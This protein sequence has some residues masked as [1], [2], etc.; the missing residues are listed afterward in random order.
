ME[1]AEFI[2]EIRRESGEPEIGAAQL[3]AKATLQTLAERLPHSE[4]LRLFL[5]LPDETK[6]WLRS[7]S[8]AGAFDIDEFLG[9]VARREGVDVETAFDH[10]RTVFFALGDAIGP[11][12]VG[13]VAAALPWTFEP[14]VAEAQHRSVNMMRAD[15]FWSRVAARL[16]VDAATARPIT[17]AVLETLAERIAAGHV[18]DLMTQLDPLLHPPLRQGLSSAL[19]EAQQMPLAVFL[20]RVG[21]LEGLAVDDAALVVDVFEHAHAVLETLAEAV[22]N[23]EWRDV[24]TDLPAEYRALMPL[25]YG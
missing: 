11:E 9:R 8:D 12:E 17:T 19:P 5:E 16:G 23:E 15:E 24:A 10:A 2:D 3:A 18:R 6:R 13:R 25:R 22:S 21:G 4:A 14:L 7:D 1:Y 20:R